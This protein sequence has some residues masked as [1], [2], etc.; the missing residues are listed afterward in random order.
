V[1]VVV[2]SYIIN[3]MQRASQLK[4]AQATGAAKLSRA[5]RVSK[6]HRGVYTGGK[7]QVVPTLPLKLAETL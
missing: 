7:W 1:V 5:W 6:Q 2:D 3:T 4:T